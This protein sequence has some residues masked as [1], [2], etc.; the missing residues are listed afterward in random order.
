MGWQQIQGHALIRD[1]KMKV[2]YILALKAITI[3]GQTD[4]ITS[5]QMKLGRLAMSRLP[6]IAYCKR[7]YLHYFITL[8]STLALPNCLVFMYPAGKIMVRS[9][10]DQIEILTRALF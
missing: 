6:P 1:I 8:K 10:L 9:K 2:Q 5:S 7:S 4:K 3:P